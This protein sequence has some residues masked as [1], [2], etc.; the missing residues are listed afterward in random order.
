MSSDNP[1]EKIE[2]A[3]NL[4]RMV[5]EDTSVPR[6]IRRIANNAIEILSDKEKSYALRASNAISLL[7]EAASD[8][9]CPIHARTRIWQII[10]IL[11]PLNR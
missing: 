10:S 9:N 7:D 3:N 1:E 6:N 11:E 5:A 4:L 2:M 8:P